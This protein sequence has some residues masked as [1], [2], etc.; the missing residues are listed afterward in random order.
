RFQTPVF[1]LSDLDIG[2]N[3]W[4]IPRLKWEDSYRPNRGRVLTAAELEAM[5]KYFRY[6][7]ENADQVA[8]RT[9]PG[10]HAKGAFFTRGSGHNKLGGY[11]EIPDEYQEV[12]DRLARKHKAAAPAVPAP[13]IRNQAD[14]TFGIIS[15]GGCDAAVREAV[16]ALAERGVIADYMRVRGFPFDDRVEAF[17]AAHDRVFIVEQNRDAQLRTLIL[18]ETQVK[19]EKLRSILVYGGFPLSSRHV[20]D[21]VTSQLGHTEG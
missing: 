9:L 14:A 7:P 19:K 20:I 16:D 21:G 3:D 10:V 11:T 4:V 12:M 18:T 5:P 1:M 2:M 6:S 15:L 8:A 17:L 13:I